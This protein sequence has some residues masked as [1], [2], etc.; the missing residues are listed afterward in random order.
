[1]EELK[2]E[3]EKLSKAYVDIPENEEKILIPFVK[4]LLELPMKERRK[5]LPVIRDLQ[6]IKSKFA[7]FSSETTCSAARA[8]FLS[9][10]QF[11][12][13]NKREMDMAYH[14]K[15]D[16]LCKLLPLYYPTWLTD[17]IN[18]DKTWLN[19]ELNYEQLMQ[20]INMGYLKDI[21][22]SRI[23]QVLPWITR[24]RN[25]DPKG[26]DTFNSELLLK[27]DITL[28][29]HIW[30]IFEYESSISY[31]DDC[32]KEAYKK[33]VT[34]R[35]E[36][37]SAALY[38]FSLDGHLD[39]ERLLKATLAAFHRSFKKDMAGWFAGFFETLQPTTEELLSLQEEMM[40]IFTSPYT[41]PVNV[42][43]QQLKSIASEK[44]FRYQEFIERAT[45]LFF[46][47]P[48]NS[49]LTIYAL[50]EKIVAQ[51]PEMKEPCCIT[52]CQLFLKK[53]ESLQKKAANFILKYGDISSSNLQETLQSYQPEMFQSVHAL[54]SLFKPQPAEEA[55]KD[56]AN[57]GETIHAEGNRTGETSL[58]EEPSP[59]TVRICREDN[60]IPFPANKEDFL[61][62]LSRLFDMEES[63]EIETTIAAIIAFHP[64]LDKE[65]FN[66]MEPVFQRAATIVANGWELYEDLLGTFLLEY[67]RLWAQK[68]TSNTGILRNMFTR[69]EEKLKGIDENREAYDK[70]SFKRLA[71]WKPSYS[72]ATCFTPIKQLWLNVI[73]KIKGG[74]AFPLLSTPTH[75]PAYVQATELIR[76]LAV[77]QK[78]GTKPCPWDF[79]LAIAR[80]AMEDKEE[81][82]AT[83]RQLLQDEYLHLCLFLLDEN[84]LP[85]PPYNQPTA[86]VAAGLV[87][88]PETEFEAFKSFA[89]NT[90]PH[91]YLTGDYEWKGVKPKK[92]PYETDRRLLQLDFHKWHTY[93]EHNSH[94]LWQEHLIINS[95][96]NMDDSY[97]M[98]PLLCCYPNR[99]E[100]LIAQIIT[101]YMAFGAPQEDNKR[102][103]TCALRMLLSF[104]CPLQEM[105]LLLLSGSLLFADKTV[106]SYAAELWVEGLSTGRVNNHR[107]GEILARLIRM[108]LAPLKRFT[109]QV[110]ESMYKRSTFHNHQLEA[111]LTVL[112][113]GLPDKPVTGLKQL[114]ELYL[115]LLTINRSNVTDEQLLQRLQEWGTNSNL[116]KVTTS[117]NN[118]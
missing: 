41:K 27:R 79:Q 24:I 108:E 101:C 104:H 38:R 65:D 20:L 113:S 7:G 34:A 94:Q 102:T 28:K 85:E 88:A 2:K 9:A 36:S 109:T 114:L 22:P 90:L 43:L 75:T 49:L 106:R 54:L 86:W 50:F 95:N 12:C 57:A 5:L 52:L 98:E 84:T 76:R 81:A 74:N 25:K 32:A 23:A 111:L 4:R 61:F 21:A 11:V 103:L 6:W 72:N 69:L 46:S 63:W 56:D 44:G 53:D 15:F 40:Q 78:A 91:N 73:R 117:L 92:E 17:F 110:Y 112:I 1:M 87:K 116:K 26:N 118:L 42:M 115:E 16:T 99:P 13:A 97:Y 8:H 29:E 105:S 51:H 19:F 55:H 33:G 93:L 70:R 77:Y 107:V 80:C 67:Q 35:D 31:Q 45:T 47:S 59:E 58:S 64:Q 100:P 71:D 89:C 39:R 82:I 14:V 60:H 96:Y 3:L 48:K 62:Q 10:V 37:I 66:R 30:T 68:D 18:D 83:A